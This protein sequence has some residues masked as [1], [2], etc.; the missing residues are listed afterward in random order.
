MTALSDIQKDWPENTERNE[1]TGVLF[2][3]LSAAFDTLSPELL[4][5]KIYA[6]AI[7]IARTNVPLSSVSPPPTIRQMFQSFHMGVGDKCKIYNQ[8]T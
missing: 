5:K 2:W 6:I 3:D 8:Q 1:T 4:C 7:A